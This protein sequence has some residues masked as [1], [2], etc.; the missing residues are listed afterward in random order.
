M[1]PP[2]PIV[3]N[4]KDIRDVWTPSPLT[5]IGLAIPDFPNLLLLQGP[6]SVGPAGTVPNQMESQITYIAKLLR[7]VVNQ[8]IRTFVPSQAAT[9]DFVAYADAFFPK[10]VFSENCKSWANGGIP[11]GR[12]HGHWPGSALHANLVRREPRWEDWQW[13]SRSESTNRFSWLG[14]GWTKKEMRGVGKGDEDWTPYLKVPGEVDLRSL[15]EEWF[16]GL[17]KA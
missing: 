3:A 7:K 1:R 5:Y 4:G 2:F 10:T 8:D 17:S 15:H 16:E 13:K 14:N 11:G 9:D 6:N 12:I